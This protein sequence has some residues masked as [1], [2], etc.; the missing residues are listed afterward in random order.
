MALNNRSLSDFLGKVVGMIPDAE[1]ALAALWT[2]TG[3]TP[4]FD[5]KPKP[6]PPMRYVNLI[7]GGGIGN[8]VDYVSGGFVLPNPGHYATEIPEEQMPRRIILY[9]TVMASRVEGQGLPVARVL[10]DAETIR[11]LE[12]VVKDPIGMALFANTHEIA[13]ATGARI[14]EEIYGLWNS[15]GNNHSIAAGFEEGKADANGLFY[16]PLYVQKGLLTKQ[17]KTTAYYGYFGNVLRNVFLLNDPHGL[18]SAYH[19]HLLTQP[20]YN[21]ITKGA[22]GKYRFDISQLEKVMPAFVKEYQEIMASKDVP[23]VI[24]L[25]EAALASVGPDTDIGKAVATVKTAG[26]PKMHRP[27][28]IVR[29]YQQE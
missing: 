23:R 28:Y 11:G 1:K 22:D 14:P 3:E 10:F 21:V 7:F 15:G 5:L 24:A 26:G 13:H 4:P 19:W 12:A 27:Y 25:H 6:I 2:A 8:S 16:L 17:Q 18:G 9:G 20:R 29:N